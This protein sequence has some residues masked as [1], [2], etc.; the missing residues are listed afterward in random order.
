MISRPIDELSLGDAEEIIRV[1]TLRDVAGFVETV[2]DRNPVHSDAVFAATT[3]FGGVIAPGIWTAGLV[4]AVIGTRL[5]G[6]GSIYLTQSLQFV[7]PVK[8][9][10]IITA[11]VEVVEILPERKRVR[12]KT[13]CVNQ[14]GEDVLTGE[15]WVRP[16]RQREVYVEQTSGMTDVVFWALQP[17]AWVSQTLATWANVG[18]SALKAATDSSASLASKWSGQPLP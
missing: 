9:G 15:A 13:V 3:P 10:D 2:G 11:R 6:P 7:K 18:V 1:V 8:L 5:P 4:S 14:R 16:P 12:L 17:C